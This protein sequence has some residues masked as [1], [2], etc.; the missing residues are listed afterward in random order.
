MSEK[1]QYTKLKMAV[2][3]SLSKNSSLIITILACL[4]FFV[5]IVTS[6]IVVV[7][8]GEYAT[9]SPMNNEL[10][11]YEADLDHDGVINEHEKKLTWKQSYDELLRQSSN[12]E[13]LKKFAD[14][15]N[16]SKEISDDQR[17]ELA[18]NEILH[19]AEDLLISTGCVIPLYNEKHIFQ[20]KDYLKG[21][22]HNVYRD[23][24]FDNAYRTDGKDEI[25][26]VVGS[27]PRTLDPSLVDQVQSATIIENSLRS[28]SLRPND[29]EDRHELG[30]IISSY[31]NQKTIFDI[32][33]GNFELKDNKYKF[34]DFAYWDD[35]KKISAKDLI[36]SINRLA[37]PVTGAP[38]KFFV[39]NIIGFDE[40]YNSEKKRIKN[41]SEL[42]KTVSFYK[43]MSG[44]SETTGSKK[45][46]DF[47]NSDKKG[48]IESIRVEIKNNSQFFK[49]GLMNTALAI[50]PVHRMTKNTGEKNEEIVSDWWRHSASNSKDGCYLCC[51][52][53]FK[54]ET[55]DIQSNGKVVLVKNDKYIKKDKIK[56]KKITFKFSNES[57]AVDDFKN[58]KIDF[59]TIISK[60]RVNDDIKKGGLQTID[61]PSSSYLFFNVNDDALDAM[62][63]EDDTPFDAEKKRQNMRYILSLLI[64]RNK[65]CDDLEKGFVSPS[66][67]IVSD[68]ISEKITPERNKKKEIIAKK[69]KEEVYW[70]QRNSYVLGE[71]NR[72][73]KRGT[74]SDKTLFNIYFGDK[75]NAN[76]EESVRQLKQKNINKVMELADEI[77]LKYTY[78]NGDLK[79]EDFPKI[80]LFIN[81]NTCSPIFEHIQSYYKK[82][83]IELHLE[84]REFNYLCSLTNSGNFC[85]FCLA[86]SADYMDPMTFLS[87]F[88]SDHVNNFCQLG[89]DKGHKSY[90]YRSKNAIK[91]FNKKKSK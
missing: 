83:G 16:I 29:R 17:I 8:K 38:F 13:D 84:P 69:E 9:H 12:L 49:E 89:K 40:W 54:F 47:E 14:K 66:R 67:G 34:L 42:N 65:I 23:T 56:L 82:F 36:W 2:K 76:Y 53:P 19:Q 33:I 4:V 50:L 22:E 43:G 10:R 91:G 11:F 28:I 46:S 86:Y 55:I 73:E 31:E 51:N 72:F 45:P 20:I 74:D 15:M 3:K 5:I 52:G 27:N 64:D 90:N 41:V 58:G 30:I 1:Q 79:F 80:T 70:C 25:T 32:Y 60:N 39:E 44:I 35:G 87:L 88:S 59:N 77:N 26:V 61:L 85:M 6:T 18:R 37:S 7:K 57:V 62:V 78:E 71:Y 75:K 24:I 21:V 68:K 48:N 81:S 63:H